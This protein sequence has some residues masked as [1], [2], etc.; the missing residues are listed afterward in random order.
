MVEEEM[1]FLE[2]VEIGDR[3]NAQR[4]ERLLTSL[5][6]PILHNADYSLARP[7]YQSVDT[8]P[9]F[10]SVNTSLEMTRQEQIGQVI[11]SSAAKD[12]TLPKEPKIPF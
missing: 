4:I 7:Q 5:S 9:Y 12:A 11:K 2:A 3:G 6:Q 1:K 8:N 10:S